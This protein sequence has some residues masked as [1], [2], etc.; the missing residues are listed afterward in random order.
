MGGLIQRRPWGY[1]LSAMVLLK[2]L[3]MGAALISMIV[4]QILA[5]LPVDPVTSAIFV[6]IS[7]AG[8][9]LGVTTLCTIRDERDQE[10]RF[11]KQRCRQK[12]GF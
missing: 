7:L 10:T 3:T 8:I 1:T 9:A 2:I 12:T 4:L 6:L 5:R 11:F